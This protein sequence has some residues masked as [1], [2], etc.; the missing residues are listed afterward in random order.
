MM[1][2]RY[3]GGESKR[4]LNNIRTFHPN[5]YIW[6][7]HANVNPSTDQK[8]TY[9][10]SS[11]IHFSFYVC[12]GLHERV[13]ECEWERKWEIIP[14]R[15]ES[16][17]PARGDQWWGE[18]ETAWGR[19]TGVCVWERMKHTGEA[20]DSVCVCREGDLQLKT[21]FSSKHRW[22]FLKMDLQKSTWFNSE[23][24]LCS[25]YNLQVHK[26]WGWAHWDHLTSK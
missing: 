1:L 6:F 15:V 4:Y 12:I 2:S 9:W 10:I 21:V 16:G 23:Y 24:S 13:V 7:T 26:K 22:L 17:R 8:V 3:L 18:A 25:V 14:G 11:L 19:P 5:V 20:A